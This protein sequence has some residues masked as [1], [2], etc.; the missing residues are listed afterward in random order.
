MIACSQKLALRTLKR[1]FQK[2]RGRLAASKRCSTISNKNGRLSVTMV[3]K[4]RSLVA[5]DV[6][7]DS[8]T[9]ALQLPEGSRRVQEK[10]KVAKAL[11]SELNG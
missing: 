10:I 2:K 5:G 4:R 7:V 6:S 9:S 1:F 11:D 3:S 8:G